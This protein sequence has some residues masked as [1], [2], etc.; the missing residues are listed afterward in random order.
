MT[1]LVRGRFGGLKTI[2]FT[3]ILAGLAACGGQQ[4]TR[5]PDEDADAEVFVER[6][7]ADQVA[8]RKREEARRKA[9]EA[10][11]Q[12][13]S[14]FRYRIDTSTE[15]PLACFVFSAALDPQKDYSPYVEFRPSFRAALTVEGRE[16]CVGGLSFGTSRTATI[17]A[18]LPAA[19]G[20]TLKRGETVPI[21]FADRPPF[22]GFKGTGVILP[23][24][25]ADGLPVETVNVDQVNVTVT[26][27][28]DRALVFKTVGQGQTTSQGQW[29]WLWG[30]DSPEDV[31]ED[32]FSGTM[33]V[34]NVQNSPVVTVFPL[35]D[36][37]GEMKP[38]AYFVKVEDAAKITDAE[39]PPAA[40]G[41]WI[42]LTDLALTAY[43][44]EQGLDV[45]LRSLKDGKTV[46][47]ATVQLIAANNT[48]LAE[49]K[50]DAS[51]RVSFDKPL[52]NGKGT[53][54]PRLVTAINARGELAALDLSRP[55]GDLSEYT[56]GGRR[57]PGPVDAFVYSD[58]GIYRP[59]ETVELT[60]LLR[61]RAGRQVTGRN[62]HLI[63]YRPNGLVASKVRF[64]DPKSG[65]VTQSF[66]VPRGASRG[67]WRASIEI[68]GLTAPAGDM[69]FAVED[70]VPQRIAVDVT[71]DEQTPMKAGSSRNVEIASRFLYGAPGA[72]LTVKAEARMEPDPKPFK[73][74]E[75]FI[76]GRHDQ[77]FEQQILEFDDTTTDGAGKATV[78]LSPGTAG[79]NSG[80]PLRLNTVVSVLEPGGR[81]V[82]ESVR[83]P[84]RPETLYLGLKPGFESSVEEGGEA[85]FEVVAVNADGA[86]SAHRL[87]WKVLRVDYHYDWYREGDSWNWRRSR[88]VTK[89][90]EGVVSTPAGGTAEIKVPGLDWGNHELIVEG[91]GANASAGASTGFY[92]GWGG[93]TSADGTE[94]PDRVKVVAAEKTPKVGQNAELTIMAP[95]DGQAQVVVATD[96]VLSVQNLTV[97]ASGTRVTLPVTEEWGEGAYV[98]VNVYSGRDPVLRAKP[99]RAIGIAH[100]PVDMGARTFALTIDSPELARPM[101]EQAI[102]VNIKGGPKE[103]VFVTVAAVDEGILQLTKFKSPDPVAHYFGRKALGV[104]LYDDYGRL[105]DP[106]LGMPAEVRSGGD[107]LGGE[108]LSVVPIKS[109]VLYSGLL[110]VGRSGKARV[111]LDIPE[112]NGELRIMA[113]AWSKTGVG[114][115][116]KKMTVRDKA[117]SDLVM[118]RFLAPGD[119]AVIT[120]SVD[121]VEL[122]S[123]QF[124]AQLS[125]NGAVNVAESA[126]TRTLQKGQRADIPV[127]LSA[128]G[129]GISTVS[130]N[131][132][133]PDNF[134]TSRSYD[135]QSR[136][137]YLPETRSMSQMMRPGETFSVSQALLAGYIPGSTEVSVGFSPLPIDAPTLYAALD[138]Y[139]YGCTEQ[140]TSRAVPLLYS[141]QLVTMGAKEAR[142]N[143]RD[144]VQTAVNTVLNRQ[145]GDGSFGLWREGDGY[146]SPWLG[147]YATDFIFR[148]KEAG[149]SVPDEALTRA[150]GALRTVATGDAWRVFGYDTDVY[151]SRY[152]NDSV[153]QMMYRSSA[154]ALYV[155]AKAGEADISRLRYLHDRELNNIQSPLAR[156]HIGAGLAYLG[157][158]A[159]AASAFKSAEQKL[160]Y[161]NT[162]DYYQ[163]PLRDLAAIVGLA[164]EAQLPEVVS[165]LGERLGKD[166][167]DAQTLTTQEKAYLL[168][169]VNSLMQGES[170]V[171]V[172]VEGL[173]NGNDND[174]QYQLSEAQAK[175]GVSFRLGGDKPLFRTVLV[176]GAPSAP[177]PAVASKLEVDK[178]FYAL[179]GSQVKLDQIDQG[180]RIVVALTITPQERRVNPVIVADLLPAG[181]EIETILRPA[182]G[183]LV[184]YDWRSGEDKVRSGAFGFLGEI[185]RPQSSQ[186]QDDRFVA[187][188]DVIEE[189]VT[190]AYVVRAVTPGSFAIPGVVAEDM[191]RPEVF[192]RS[193][194]GRVTVLASQGAAGGR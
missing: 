146:A 178:R 137:P 176:T 76:Y 78:R 60:A 86:A 154:Y 140:I 20:R 68:D 2:L 128:S 173:G 33:D 114:S 120:A 19:D 67:E 10:E 17:L 181:F 115:A 142:D 134:Q 186:S 66:A 44:G 174:R 38:G 98:M 192:A 147:A 189:P 188:I 153:Q 106:N 36:V 69:R 16:L 24:E 136:S 152:S 4:Q 15:Q 123:G 80:I 168:L 13:F 100:V 23:R 97:S 125:A 187:A 151:E 102:E 103:P 124:K 130:L 155:L 35:Q 34:D 150:Y 9:R 87:S 63:I 74:F 84:Y 121:N 40:S 105:L 45:T 108:G 126:L 8:A 77:N 32:I 166:V 26:R 99:R 62:G 73:A 91:Q 182:D 161:R 37:V 71:A 30:E 12:D 92:V 90:N 109:V 183:R 22:V 52:M 31:G 143:P 160:G 95:Y 59:G 29:W 112:F 96:R 138:R 190:L 89:V 139:P 51:G 3:F 156:A 170:N 127:R 149:Y 169:A 193:A 101:G 171:Q 110:E 6:S 144:K 175:S 58:R 167:P 83:V 119:E 48:V 61:D 28:N 133:G 42:L 185:A 118:P 157:D 43:Y 27:I 81:A 47:D 70:F 132:S 54:A 122:A 79:S 172:K 148:A 72:G 46:S 57:T 164:A 158:R 11:T 49:T 135:I 117:P 94:A 184:E 179:S 104:E 55:P 41:R 39:G 107:Q 75:G 56:V 50:P 141:E 25:N 7:P 111:R 21:D 18:G 93:W 1:S 53:M 165:R 85:K 14:Y 162:G 64:T 163:T 116:D 194:P 177:P 5:T 82:S 88:T 131:V 180:E 113:V 159:R 145:G 65:A 191:Y 129:E